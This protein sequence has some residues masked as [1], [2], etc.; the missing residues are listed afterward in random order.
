MPK[1]AMV[2]ARVEPRLKNRAER[3]LT[4]LGLT[5]TEAIT[6]FYRQVEMRNGLPFDVVIPN[7]TTLRTLRDVEAGRDLIVSD[8][9]DAMF[10]KLG[11]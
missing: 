3:V 10:K 9:A 2:R 6:I 5:A 8:S 1:T 11:I 7:A 4:R